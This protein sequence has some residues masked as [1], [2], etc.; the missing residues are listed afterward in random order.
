M[1]DDNGDDKQFRTTE[2]NIQA[3]PQKK[4]LGVSPTFFWICIGVFALV[5]ILGTVMLTTIITKVNGYGEICPRVIYG[6]SIWG[7]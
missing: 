1:P 6:R 5:L 2:I 4:I 3:K 7:E